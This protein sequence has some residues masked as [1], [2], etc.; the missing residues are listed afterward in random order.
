[1]STSAAILVFLLVG[2]MLGADY[3]QAVLHRRAAGRGWPPPHPSV[4][5]WLLIGLLYLLVHQ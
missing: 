3:V 4:L 1:V 5:A 2:L